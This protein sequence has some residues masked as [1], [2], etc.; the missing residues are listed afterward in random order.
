MK[1][2]RSPLPALAMLGILLAPTLLAL[3]AGSAQTGPQVSLSFDRANGYSL[4]VTGDRMKLFG[5]AIDA[6]A[7]ETRWEL[8]LLD[9]SGAE[10]A[11]ADF[12]GS[13]FD[14]NVSLPLTEGD[15]RGVWVGQIRR[16]DPGAAAWVVA[17]TLQTGVEATPVPGTPVVTA[18]AH[19]ANVV[20]EW[21]TDVVSAR[22]EV[23]VSL[24]PTF[25]D[26]LLHLTAAPGT[27]YTF[28]GH[29]GTTYHVRVRVGDPYGSTSAWNA[30]QVTTKPPVGTVAFERVLYYVGPA[31]GDTVRA[32]VSALATSDVEWRLDVLDPL[33]VLVDRRSVSGVSSVDL[34]SAPIPLTGAHPRGEWRAEVWSKRVGEEWKLWNA[35][36]S[37][38]VDAL[39]PAAPTLLVTASGATLRAAWLPQ[40]GNGAQTFDVQVSTSGQ[41][42][43]PLPDLVNVS[44][45]SVDYAGTWDTLYHVRARGR[46][47]YGTV[48][49]WATTT[50]RTDPEPLPDLAV[51][52]GNVW[53]SPRDVYEGRTATVNV[54]VE[55]QGLLAA[56]NAEFVLQAGGVTVASVR[57]S[58]PAG[59]G[60]LVELPYTFTARGA[61]ALRVVADPSGSIRETREANN[62]VDLTVQVERPPI[63]LSVVPADVTLSPAQAVA[64][65]PLAVSAVVRNLG[66][67]PTGA[68]PVALLV[69]GA[70][71]AQTTVSLGAGGSTTVSFSWTPPSATAYVLTVSA[72][73][74]NAI[75][76][77]DETNNRAE[78]RLTAGAT[79]DLALEHFGLSAASA[80][81]GSSVTITARVRN[82][83]THPAPATTVA[84]LATGGGS[85]HTAGTLSVPALGIG[86]SATLTGSWVVPD[87]VAYA[88][89]AKLDPANAL[90]ETNEG[91]NRLTASFTGTPVPLPDVRVVLVSAPSDLRHATGERIQYRVSN[92]G[93]AP[94]RGLDVVIALEDLTRT[95]VAA[96][97][98]ARVRIEYLPAGE[99]RDL[100][101]T[102]T[103][104][105]TFGFPEAATLT[106]TASHAGVDNAPGDERAAKA[107]RVV[108]PNLVVTA[109][110]AALLAPHDPSK[111]LVRP[112]TYVTVKNAGTAKAEAVELLYTD[113]S[114]TRRWT[115]LTDK[116]APAG[117]RPGES[118]Q[119]AL[120]HV[121]TPSPGIYP[122][123][124]SADVTRATGSLAAQGGVVESAEPTLDREPDI[125]KGDNSVRPIFVLPGM[126][127]TLK[128]ASVL[129]DVGAYA[130]GSEAR[131]TVAVYGT[132]AAR[133][134]ERLPSAT[135]PRDAGWTVRRE[136]G[137][138]DR[139][140]S[141]V[142]E[143]AIPE[144][145]G[146]TATRSFKVAIP[147]RSDLTNIYCPLFGS[148]SHGCTS[149][150]LPGY[151]QKLTGAV[152]GVSRG[153]AYDLKVRVSHPATGHAYEET[154]LPVVI[155]DGVL[156]R[157]HQDTLVFQ[158]DGRSE[159]LHA[160]VVAVKD[161]VLCEPNNTWWVPDWLYR[162]KGIFDAVRT[163]DATTKEYLAFTLDWPQAGYLELKAPSGYDRYPRAVRLVQDGRA[164][165]PVFHI[166]HSG[167]SF[168]TPGPTTSAKLLP[169]DL[170]MRPGGLYVAE[171]LVQS[172]GFSPEEVHPAI[173]RLCFPGD[174]VEVWDEAG[175]GDWWGPGSAD[176]AA[177]FA[178]AG[179]APCE[180]GKTAS[181]RTMPLTR[182]AL[183]SHSFVLRPRAAAAGT[184]VE[185]VAEVYDENGNVPVGQ[186]EFG[187]RI[188]QSIPVDSGA[189]GL[190]TPQFTAALHARVDRAS[191]SAQAAIRDNDERFRNMS[192]DMA[193]T[194]ADVVLGHIFNKFGNYLSKEVGYKD[195]VDRGVGA[196]FPASRQLPVE[197]AVGAFFQTLTAGDASKSSLAQGVQSLTGVS[198]TT[199]KDIATGYKARI[200]RGEFIPGRVLSPTDARDL[201]YKLDVAHN[202]FQAALVKEGRW[203][204]PSF[205]CLKPQ[206]SPPQPGQ[207][208]DEPVLGS[209]TVCNNREMHPMPGETL[210]YVN[211]LGYY[212]SNQM[213]HLSDPWIDRIRT[214]TDRLVLGLTVVGV[215]TGGGSLAAA[216]AIETASLAAD[217]ALAAAKLDIYAAGA[218]A[219][220]MTQAS[221]GRLFEASTFDP[222]CCTEYLTGTAT[223]GSIKSIPLGTASG[224]LQHNVSLL[225]PAGQP[226]PTLAATTPAGLPVNAT[227][228]S[229]PEGTRLTLVVPVD[230]PGNASL[231]VV[232]AR[233]GAPLP[234]TISVGQSLADDVRF[235]RVNVTAG[236]RSVPGLV[237]HATVDGVD[238][239]LSQL[240]GGPLEVRAR[241]G[242]V[243][244]VRAEA[245]GHAPLDA[246]TTVDLPDRF[247]NVDLLM[248]PL[249][250]G[251]AATKATVAPGGSVTL[252]VAIKNPTGAAATYAARIEGFSA[253][254]T[255]QVTAKTLSAGQGGNLDVV[256]RAADRM[257][258]GKLA[259]RLVLTDD[260]GNALR[261]LPLT[262]LVQAPRADIR[263][264]P[265]DAHAI[266]GRS[267]TYTFVLRNAGNAPMNT[268]QVSGVGASWVTVEN[269]PSTLAAGAEATLTLRLAPPAGTPAGVVVAGVSVKASGTHEVNHTFSAHVYV[270]TLGSAPKVSV[271]SGDLDGDGAADALRAEVSGGS[272]FVGLKDATGARVGIDLQAHTLRAGGP[273]L[274]DTQGRTPVHA[275]GV[276]EAVTLWTGSSASLTR[277][278][279]VVNGE[280]Q[281]S[282]EPRVDGVPNV[283][284]ETLYIQ[285]GHL[286][287]DVAVGAWTGG[288]RAPALRYDLGAAERTPALLVVDPAVS[289]TLR[290]STVGP[291]DA[292]EVAG[293]ESRMTLSGTVTAVFRD[294]LVLEDPSGG[295]FLSTGASPGVLVGDVGL[296]QVEGDGEGGHRLLSFHATGRAQPPV[297]TVD[298]AGLAQRRADNRSVVVDVEG[299]VA[300]ASA[301]AVTLQT[302][303]GAVTV[304]F[305]DRAAPALAAGETFTARGMATGAATL[306]AV[307][308]SLVARA[309]GPLSNGWYT[310]SPT[311][312]YAGLGVGAITHRVDQGPWSAYAG[313][314]VLQGEGMRELRGQ[315]SDA[316]GNV[317]P[318]RLRVG[319]DLAPPAT[320]HSFTGPTSGAQ[321]TWVGPLTRLVLAATDA[322][323]GVAQTTLCLRGACAAYDAP[324]PLAGAEGA[325]TAAYRSRDVAGREE[326]NATLSLAY[327]A[328]PPTTEVILQGTRGNAGWWRSEV[329]VDFTCQ[330]AGSGCARVEG[331]LDGGAWADRTAGF[332]VST[333]LNHSLDFRGVDRVGNVEEAEATRVPVDLQPP[334]TPHVFNGVRHLQDGTYHVPA[335]TTID[336]R[337]FDNA[338]GVAST[339]WALDGAPREPW[340]KV[341]IRL[342]GASGPHTLAFS[343]ED[344]A[345]H[346]EI[347]RALRLHLDVDAPVTNVTHPPRNSITV[348]NASVYLDPPV[349]VVG[350]RR[351]A[352]DQ[353]KGVDAG[354]RAIIA[355]RVNV[356]AT[357]TDAVPIARVEF[358]LD[359]ETV[360]RKS[361]IG[362][363][364]YWEWDVSGETPGN[365]TL[366]LE[367]WDVLGNHGVLRRDVT[368]VAIPARAGAPGPN[369]NTQMATLINDMNLCVPTQWELQRQ[370]LQD[371]IATCIRDAVRRLNGGTLPLGTATV[372]PAGGAGDVVSQAR[373]T[374]PEDSGAVMPSTTPSPSE[375]MSTMSPVRREHRVLAALL[376]GLFLT[377]GAGGVAVADE[378][379]TVSPATTGASTA[380]A[381][382][383]C[384]TGAD[385]HSNANFASFLRLDVS[386]S[387]TL[388]SGD[389][390][391][392]YAFPAYYGDHVSVTLTRSGSYPT[393]AC[394]LNPAF[395]TLSCTWLSEQPATLSARVTMSGD[396]KFSVY[397]PQLGSAAYQLTATRTLGADEDC[398]TGGDAG[399]SAADASLLLVPVTRCEPVFHAGDAADWYRFHAG[400]GHPVR[401]D[402]W[403]D[404]F[405]QGTAC[406]H[407]PAPGAAPVCQTLAAASTATLQ[408]VAPAEG[409]WRLGIVPTDGVG[410]YTLSVDVNRHEGAFN[411][412]PVLRNLDCGL[413]APGSL[414]VR[415]VIAAADDTGELAYYVSWGDGTRSVNWFAPGVTQEVT[416]T[417]AAAGAYV[418]GVMLE[419]RELGKRL[420]YS[421]RS[422]TMRVV[423]EPGGAGDVL[424][425]VDG[426][427]VAGPEK[428]DLDADDDRPG[429]VEDALATDTGRA[430]IPLARRTNGTQTLE[431]LAASP[432]SAPACAS[433]YDSQMRPLAMPACAAQAAGGAFPLPAGTRFVALAPEGGI[434]SEFSARV[435]A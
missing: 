416:H 201:V 221:I 152:D 208:A 352:V 354:G 370:S 362:G 192:L 38:V 97:E 390:T 308:P 213:V 425:G 341:P 254:V 155:Q 386:C 16:L 117:L 227:V 301:A 418:V 317:A 261:E 262:L 393:R 340:L 403:T 255:A 186:G 423:L 71:V 41:F 405:S 162:C 394:L 170:R 174:K 17:A 125:L 10:R 50:L 280:V 230:A 163:M 364:Y 85:T 373:V 39:A 210:H 28:P 400:A 392:Y 184:S 196:F 1:P 153:Y 203:A 157:I 27:S 228:E 247:G 40:G 7:P 363:P 123:F 202:A 127:L 173:V 43:F 285:R 250:Q 74:A 353:P 293:R 88:F 222:H 426:R 194:A 111:G 161:G 207:P 72:D 215:V 322:A 140:L 376:A 138:F 337:P 369:M 164:L 26:P 358:F 145:V 168:V 29:F 334:W 25:A 120:P 21:T 332:V 167:P 42:T 93:T 13:T 187:V 411:D 412:R 271:P 309:E 361:Q 94:V 253:G 320:A 398:F 338:S 424:R 229:T 57:A 404:R 37:R 55:N 359:D 323:S 200:D 381:Q 3:P 291:V 428:G 150:D 300:S 307:P 64:Q 252:P 11:R 81:T 237:L 177:R 432:G 374:G 172:R 130:P 96:Q 302:P 434:L 351:I 15:L 264:L 224:T 415:C 101:A 272:L 258:P 397:L 233:E 204:M 407:S 342:T 267:A 83:G 218:V 106:V 435:R 294:G 367:A 226:L 350:D 126:T 286:A 158:D 182:G 231:T 388:P 148:W 417:Y 75:K 375:E 102:L 33:G 251:P 357:A 311:V 273:G 331:S 109:P 238:A 36:V 260:V 178:D 379:A 220:P 399:G 276:N 290:F 79:T 244:R 328:T 19:D 414:S 175:Q 278:V 63:D 303:T 327:D 49:P 142:G 118:A 256:L 78:K 298:A 422:Y 18:R 181:F 329:R 348:D 60:A 86:E 116:L 190:V 368:V 234:Y 45:R 61:V 66:A 92:K 82:V 35:S 333:Q 385:A 154:V 365:H 372:S 169:S 185:L 133:Y 275:L 281:V 134:L 56:T 139:T 391:D 6:V 188:R 146:L 277:I 429:I 292:R 366:R 144:L 310:A 314:F 84:V 419:D 259:G 263:G 124:F 284:V 236:G 288:V 119:V 387:G 52:A 112:P 197:M 107:V 212:H 214:A 274:F 137:D 318:A 179:N 347:D 110:H 427:L 53:L 410:R 246:T 349:V 51:S 242:A 54:R 321:P 69:D 389:P 105:R 232:G 48:G 421:D 243:L 176:V 183:T 335:S 104:R 136:S 132:D 100:A 324:A 382:D 360:S 356:T 193:Q 122:V 147:T 282:F 31:G 128:P 268:I 44:Q 59:Q 336:L 413:V 103:A 47:A 355:R 266:A 58:V 115:L 241:Q 223:P 171:A 346:V 141:V 420:P 343:S 108:A 4:G 313:P 99:D 235:V 289:R 151:S 76:E 20:V 408:G 299:T 98:L 219:Y 149:N 90:A 395:Q 114:G 73:P 401:V 199:V 248:A 32:R 430:W 89:E 257:L 68:V 406:L 46:D 345:G 279:R 159:A 245:P 195:A 80:T 8:R 95:P 12:I 156:F 312:S 191:G 23:Q 297:P 211:L 205:S 283:K 409:E 22:S 9:P 30:T 339:T 2:V 249:L 383:D 380:A 330:D 121:D 166:L 77:T 269:A 216:G 325:F 431:V 198:G 143:E 67:E 371:G 378:G 319:V 265:L 295:V 165:S 433:A 306:R 316:L 344:V 65:Q 70:S 384:G 402:L 304:S 239:A 34:S 160:D 377:G 87:D 180:T 129:Y 62:A 14:G 217:T 305:L 296:A 287:D 113:G 135:A 240:P 24:S 315:G 91:N 189:V 326:D 131:L 225:V 206:A 270:D 396:W 5:K 209:Q